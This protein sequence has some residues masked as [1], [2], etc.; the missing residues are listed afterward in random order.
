MY[1]IKEMAQQQEKLVRAYRRLS[2]LTE[3]LE[4]IRRSL[5]PQMDAGQ[6]VGLQLDRLLVEMKMERD[7]VKRMADSLQAIGAV[8]AAAD[9]ETMKLSQALPGSGKGLEKRRQH[10]DSSTSVIFE[11]QPGMTIGSHLAVEGWLAALAHETSRKK[12]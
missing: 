12:P 4:V 8:F 1:H 5:D 9:R 10:P 11:T 6:G 3:E 2:D 7:Q